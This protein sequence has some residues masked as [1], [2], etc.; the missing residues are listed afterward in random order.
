MRTTLLAGRPIYR[1]SPFSDSLSET[2]L[3]ELRGPS[4]AAAAAAAA[5]KEP[6]ELVNTFHRFQF[7]LIPSLSVPAELSAGRHKR[8]CNFGAAI[9]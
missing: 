8:L 6:N 7:N 9:N 2:F 1:C 5:A 4:G 3:G